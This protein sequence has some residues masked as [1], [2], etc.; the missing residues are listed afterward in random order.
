M[1]NLINFDENDRKNESPKKKQKNTGFIHP[2][3][4][5]DRL[6]LELNNPFDKLEYRVTHLEDPFECLE[7]NQMTTSQQKVETKMEKSEKIE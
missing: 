1:E 4:V 3:L 6:S 2:L 7:K 5:N